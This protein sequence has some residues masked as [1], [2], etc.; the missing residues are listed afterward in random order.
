[1]G[2]GL[3]GGH[4]HHRCRFQK[5]SLGR[6]STEKHS[7]PRTQRRGGSRDGVWGREEEARRRRSEKNYKHCAGAAVQVTQNCRRSSDGGS[8]SVTL[9]ARR[10]SCA[11]GV[12]AISGSYFRLCFSV[13]NKKKS[14]VHQAVTLRSNTLMQAAA[15][16]HQDSSSSLIA[17]WGG[18]RREVHLFSC[19][20]NLA[21]G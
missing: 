6:E 9:A 13:K 7:A 14:A 20:N 4:C 8:Q 11:V 12:R 19:T 1:M 2:E 21:C 5:V 18:G 3:E 17:Q 15:K 10:R 16:V